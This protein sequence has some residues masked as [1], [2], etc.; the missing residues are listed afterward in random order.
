MNA[1]TADPTAGLTAPPAA[2]RVRDLFHAE[3]P[4]HERPYAARERILN[5]LSFTAPAGQVTA[6]AGSNGSGK[7][8]A[9]RV[10]TGAIAADEGTVEVLGRS[11][12]SAEAALPV[13]ASVVPDVLPYPGTWTVHDIARLRQNVAT[14]FDASALGRYLRQNG[15]PLD[16]DV[17]DLSKGQATQLMVGSAL[18]EGPRLLIMDEPLSRLDPLARQQLVDRLREH[19]AEEGSSLLMATHD[20]AGMERFV[21]HLVVIADG[22]CVLE[23]DVE[24]LRDRWMIVEVPG[25]IPDDLTLLGEEEAGGV[26]HGLIDA[27]D[28]AGLP[29]D[30]RLRRPDVTDLVTFTLREATSRRAGLRRGSA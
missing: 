25:P 4:R 14:R 19:M 2:V 24:A 9:L 13:G 29:A 8:T 22:A 26:I 23:G 1:S 18:A 20:L 5:G 28:A 7:T 11:M 3:I 15:V 21:D 12:G 6:I 16:R 10:I 27:D 30:G 17:Q